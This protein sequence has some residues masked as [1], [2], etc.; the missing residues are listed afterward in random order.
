M[1]YFIEKHAFRVLIEYWI[2]VNSS[3]FKQYDYN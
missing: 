3:E 1:Y 2:N